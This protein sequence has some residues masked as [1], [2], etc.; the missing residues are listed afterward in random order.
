MVFVPEKS[1][2]ADN[3]RQ[4]AFQ[5]NTFQVVQDTND[6]SRILSHFSN[7]K[8][9]ESSELK[10]EKYSLGKSS[11]TRLHEGLGNMKQILLFV[12]DATHEKRLF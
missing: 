3:K 7:T 4:R 9:E 11:C 10:S 1:C 8:A 2:Y 5:Q 6:P 12:Q